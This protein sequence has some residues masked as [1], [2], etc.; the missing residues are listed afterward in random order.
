MSVSGEQ[1]V[2][3]GLP[4]F[5]R[6]S[7]TAEQVADRLGPLADLVG[8]WFGSRGFNLIAV[9][10]GAHGFRL[11][12]N[13]IVETITFTPIGA[14]VPNRGGAA[15]TQRIPGLHYDIRV[16]DAETN[17]PLHIENGMWLLLTDPLNPQD[18]KVARLASVP[19]GDSVLCLGSFS[20]ISGPPAISARSAMPE[21][22]QPVPLGYLDPYSHPLPPGFFPSDYTQGLVDLL[23]TQKV[24]KTTTLD[25]STVPDGGI[26]NIPF[27]TKHADLKQFFSVLWIEVV[28]NPNDAT[29]TFDQLQYA[30]QADLHFLPRFDDPTKLICWPHVT[31]NT[32]V[33]Q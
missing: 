25:V 29:Q 23:K 32:L 33:K 5:I 11:L 14:D 22:G 8:T 15:G 6:L 9:P 30:Q 10:E 3:A 1:V 16:A 12:I 13:P 19:H 17:T 18:Q 4:N 21:T 24:T 27:I 26:V 20:E 7:G 2:T 28:E 31:I